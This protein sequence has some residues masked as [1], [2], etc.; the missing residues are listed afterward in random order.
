MFQR[1]QSPQLEG[2]LYCEN[3]EGNSQMLDLY[4]ENSQILDLYEE[5]S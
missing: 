2:K 5:N 1:S 4:E 3:Y